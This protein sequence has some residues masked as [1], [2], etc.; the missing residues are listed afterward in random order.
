MTY[1]HTMTDYKEAFS[2]HGFLAK[3]IQGHVPT[4][5]A[6]NA[7]WFA[8]ADKL[9]DRLQII[10][11][12]GSEQITG[13]KRGGSQSP[14][15]VATMLMW[16]CLGNYQGMVLMAERGMNAEA[17][18]LARS[19]LEA[20]FQLAAMTA[21]TPEALDLIWFDAAKSRRG[22]YKFILEM[23]NVDPIQRTAIEAKLA[24]LNARID[25]QLAERAIRLA[26][27][28]TGRRLP[29]TGVKTFADKGPLNTQYLHYKHLSDEAA[30][31]SL[32]SMHKHLNIAPDGK[33]WSNFLIGP[34]ED[35]GIKQTLA[36]ASKF[37][38]YVGVA[39][40]EITNIDFVDAS[41]IGA[42]LEELNSKLAR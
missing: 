18:I 7:D 42:E 20:C 30:H 39:Y 40:A 6:A 3:E 26:L 32:S 37:M 41:D 9:N 31:P 29:D 2:K 12:D 19:L 22:L 33:S 1:L 4:I 38:F 15:T 8:F 34:N 14:E 13:A 25:K 27:D 23:D 17:G 21:D 28:P 24:E 36:R 35:G 5:R 11:I 16:R 10:A